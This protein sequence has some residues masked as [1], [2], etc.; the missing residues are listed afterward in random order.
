V[1][2]VHLNSMMKR[3]SSPLIPCCIIGMLCIYIFAERRLSRFV[4]EISFQILFP[5][6]VPR[7]RSQILSS[8]TRS[9]QVLSFAGIAVGDRSTY[10][11]AS[12]SS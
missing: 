7:F 3:C 12:L 8:V 10:H 9:L 1:F 5:D 6:F 4:L 2:T 11:G